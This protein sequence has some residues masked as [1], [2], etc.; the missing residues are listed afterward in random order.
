MNIKYE[1]LSILGKIWSIRELFDY[2]VFEDDW[3]KVETAIHK[4]NHLIADAET[5]NP[6]IEYFKEDCEEIQHNAY[7]LALEFFKGKTEETYEEIEQKGLI[8]RLWFLKGMLDDFKYGLKNIGVDQDSDEPLIK[9]IE[10]SINQMYYKELKERVLTNKE[11]RDLFKIKEE[12][13]DV[14]I[15]YYHNVNL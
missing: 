4:L 9:G 2:G 8:S 13:E 7:V 10:K 5:N 12:V 1:K 14:R 6:N 3:K 11:R 15:K